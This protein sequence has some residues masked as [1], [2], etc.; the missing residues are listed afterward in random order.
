MSRNRNKPPD[1]KASGSEK[2]LSEKRDRSPSGDTSIPKKLKYTETA[3]GPSKP[4]KSTVDH[5]RKYLAEA[6][7]KELDKL[8]DFLIRRRKK[9]FAKT[10]MEGDGKTINQRQP[11]I[12][13]LKDEGSR[14]RLELKAPERIPPKIARKITYRGLAEAHAE[15]FPDEPYTTP[16]RKRSLSER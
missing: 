13:Q 10:M 16:K 4:G 7:D 12:T 8:T 2:L 14:T 3:I 9:S 5:V 1:R 6:S 11:Q 15:L